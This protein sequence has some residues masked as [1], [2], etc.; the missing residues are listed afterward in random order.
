MCARASASKGLS[1]CASGPASGRVTGAF[2]AK[3]ALCGEP[4]VD[5]LGRSGA[6]WS[7]FLVAESDWRVGKGQDRRFAA[8]AAVIGVMTWNPRGLASRCSASTR[9]ILEES[10]SLSSKDSE[11][12]E[13]RGYG[14]APLQRESFASRRDGWSQRPCPPRPPPREPM[15]CWPAATE[16]R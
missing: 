8:V 16:A 12:A 6:S 1:S 11:M 3:R 2:R 5:M 15:V 4:P 9:E 14:I 13:R 10:K 7:P